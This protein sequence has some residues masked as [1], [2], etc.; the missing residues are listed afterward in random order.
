MMG[1]LD[2]LCQTTPSHMP[3]LACGGETMAGL[4]EG[5]RPGRHRRSTEHMF[6]SE[7]ALDE[8]KRWLHASAGVMLPEPESDS[9]TFGHTETILSK[10][11][12]N[13]SYFNVF[14]CFFYLWP[15]N[16]CF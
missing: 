16:T 12:I 10:T 3:T 6:N 15:L 11:W 7:G 5:G 13:T 4:G 14:E 9:L 2:A 1:H 8:R